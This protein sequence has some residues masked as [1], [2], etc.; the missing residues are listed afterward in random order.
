MNGEVHLLQDSFSS[1]VDL[2]VC[3]WVCVRVCACVCAGMHVWVCVC[4]WERERGGERQERERESGSVLFKLV[5]AWHWLLFYCQ[6]FLYKCLGVILRK[7][8]KKDLVT[9]HLDII[10]SSVKHTDQ[11]E[12][13]VGIALGDYIVYM[14]NSGSHFSPLNIYMCTEWFD[15]VTHEKSWIGDVRVYSLGGDPVQLTWC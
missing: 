8:T 2:C 13:E 1:L 9:K 11:T 10:F 5:P 15:G 6:N 4:A 7:S 3:D 14:H 12:R